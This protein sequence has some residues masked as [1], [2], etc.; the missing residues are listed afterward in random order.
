MNPITFMQ[1][2]DSSTQNNI[3]LIKNPMQAGSGQAKVT[4]IP[5]T[6]LH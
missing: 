4:L 2:G 3:V 1:K 5:P 6:H